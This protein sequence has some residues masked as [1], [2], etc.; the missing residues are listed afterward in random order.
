MVEAGDCISGRYVYIHSPYMP[1]KDMTYVWSVECIFVSGTYMTITC[2]I[3]VVVGCVGHT[4]AP[5]LDPF[6][7]TL[8]LV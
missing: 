7:Y 1:L 6:V 3:N 4:C 5:I 2:E 8:R